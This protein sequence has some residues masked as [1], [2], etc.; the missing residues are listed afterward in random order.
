[1]KLGAYDYLT[2][3]AR[4]EELELVV[5]RAAEK[6]RLR[7][8]NEGLKTRIERLD[9]PSGIVTEDPAMKELLGVLARVAGSELPVLVQGES[10]TGK[11]LVARALHRQS[12][13]AGHAFVAINCGALP[14]NLLESEL[15]GHE[16]GAFTG[17]VA[18]KPGLFEV[19][20]RGV[21]FLDEIGEVSPAVQ[22]KLLRVLETKEF[23]R[24]GSTRPQR[25]DLRIVS[26][27]NRDLK[28]ETRSGGF[29]EDLYYRLNG[30]TVRLPPLRERRG[31]VPLLARHFLRQ[32]GSKKAF[33]PRAI[34]ALAGYAWPGNVRE[35][36]MVVHRAM[37]LA[38]GE[39]IDA[40]DLPAAEPASGGSGFLES[41]LGAGLTLE[42]LEREYIRRV[43]EQHQGHRGRTAKALGIDPKT[44]YNKLGA[45]RPRRA[46]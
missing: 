31:D 39:L 32:L 42:E 1:M 25:S 36:Q 11:E 14:E 16:K 9:A 10:G 24:L 7:R 23:T 6:S 45:E 40:V 37:I 13:R 3:P 44:L 17:A 20:D 15:F 27:S 18:R 33:A 30:V 2:K 28:Q 21:L 5:A 26:A 46:H 38:P 4:F 22:V 35:L 12:P 8:E 34:E 29:R 41:A 19:A 43:L